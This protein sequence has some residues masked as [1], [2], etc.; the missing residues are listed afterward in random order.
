MP[1][2]GDDLLVVDGLLQYSVLRTLLLTAH[3]GIREARHL[4]VSLQGR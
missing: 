4:Y 2:R 1:E 3:V